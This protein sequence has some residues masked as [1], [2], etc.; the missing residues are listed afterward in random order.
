MIRQSPEEAQKRFAID[1]HSI[2]ADEFANRYL[3]LNADAYGS[4]FTY[5][6][7]RLDELL[8]RY[9]P[10]RGAALSLL[11]VGCGTGHHMAALRER[12]FEVAGVDGSEEMLEHARAQNPG[13]EVR[14]A[15]VEAIPFPDASFDFVV[16]IEVL[17]YLP[18]SARCIKEM[19]RVLKPG[20]VCLA[21]ATPA[22][23]LNGYWLVNRVAN[24]MRVSDL[25]RLK[26]FFTTS[27]RLRREF[28][29]AGFQD[30]TVHGV[31]L[32]PINWVE[33][34]MP[35]VLPR[36]LRAWEKADARLADRV[37]LREL[38]NMFLVQATR[39]RRAGSFI[40]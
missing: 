37:I 6:R 12:G 20:G 35:A 32:G 40:E 26:Q 31:Y 29:E 5:S 15:D 30:S 27:S 23:N 11:D 13:S 24:R 16:C 9:L 19:A 4:C 8:E 39:S 17:R 22:F 1:Q 14:H 36:V 38:S 7:R 3:D 28:A 33:R 10:R 25:V 34:L 2:Q 18:G 21:T